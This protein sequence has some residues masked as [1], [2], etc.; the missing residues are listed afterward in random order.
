MSDSTDLFVYL[1]A[2]LL[3]LSSF[4]L[5]LQENPY[6]ALVI[7]GI[8]GAVAAMVYAVLGAADVALTEALMGTMLAIT[9]YAVA[10]RSSLVMRLGVLA[11]EWT[12]QDEEDE[13]ATKKQSSPHFEALM[14]EFR[15][16]LGKHHL[17]LELVSYDDLEALEAALMS[18]EIHSTCT[19]PL[20][21]DIHKNW[22]SKTPAPY[23]I[24]IRIPRLYEI[25]HPE[26]A[27]P[28]Q[29]ILT[30]LNFLNLEEKQK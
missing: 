11:D 13:A 25:L 21:T 7:R 23:Q 15:R 5:V 19:P 6:H 22:G 26:L 18:K 8:L 3:P 24:V 27:S 29:E 20:V 16:I 30:T 2:A 28:R 4:I 12:Y 9:L 1:A 17:R 10:V 14:N